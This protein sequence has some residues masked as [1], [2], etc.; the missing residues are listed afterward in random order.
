MTKVD[1]YSVAVKYTGSF[2]DY[3]QAEWRAKAQ[4]VCDRGV[5]PYDCTKEVETFEEARKLE[6]EFNY[7]ADNRFPCNK[8]AYVT[9]AEIREQ[10]WED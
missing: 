4:Y 1:F 8:L 9:W 5:D 7:V 6:D 3:T 2:E 10:D